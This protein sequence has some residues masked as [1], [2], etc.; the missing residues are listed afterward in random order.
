M[1]LAFLMLA[2]VFAYA[3]QALLALLASRVKA[4]FGLSDASLGVLQ[5]LA[6]NLS[7][8]IALLFVGPLVDKIDRVKLLMCAA[9]MWSV[10]TVLTGLAHEF[11]QLFS[12]RVG[13]GIAEAAVYPSAFSLIADLY[14][15][16]RRALVV[17]IF[18]IGTLAG[19]SA[20]TAISGALIR[21]LDVAI[22]AHT[23]ALWML[24]AWR[25]AFVAA[26]LP[27][28]AL[29]VALA[30]SREPGR[31]QESEVLVGAQTPGSFVG[32]LVEKRLLLGR[33]VGAI[34]LSQF[35]MA[36]MIFWI[37]STFTRAFAFSAGQAGEWLGAIF[38]LGSLSG[39]AVG[40]VLL[41]LLSRRY[42]ATAPLIVLKTAV[43]LAALTVLIIPFANSPMLLATTITGFI[44]SVYVGITVAPSL[45]MAVAPNHLRG[46]L[47]SLETLILIGST[48]VT[49]P[50]VGALSDHVFTG[51]HGLALALSAVAIPGNLLAPLLLR[52][53]EHLLPQ[54]QDTASRAA[55]RALSEAS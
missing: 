53:I 11:W 27:G 32:F 52:R 2:A 37:P 36:S 31:R 19:A 50:L 41:S 3:D 26:A 23:G 39:L 4:S 47:I 9:G 7:T 22:A 13:V 21:A 28:F 6:L 15:P 10:F 46:R 30:A 1:L 25:V 38:G 24:P 40:T 8:A 20:A 48:A 12:C 29:V 14:S 54:T 49:P 16:K 51:P 44:G 42:E 5:G 17:S 34:V 43:I 33:L 45:L 55:N 35:G 18:L